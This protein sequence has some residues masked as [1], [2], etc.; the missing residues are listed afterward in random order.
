MPNVSWGFLALLNTNLSIWACDESY[1]VHAWAQMPQILHSF[2]SIGL[3][4]VYS[5]QLKGQTITHA[6][7]LTHFPVA[8]TLLARASSKL[9]LF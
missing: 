3:S 2:V 1:W 5:R 8:M 6:P 9:V 4:S 7:Q